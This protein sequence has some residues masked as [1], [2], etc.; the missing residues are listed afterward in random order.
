LKRITAHKRW[1]PEFANRRARV[2]LRPSVEDA[3][4]D[5]I[6]DRKATRKKQ[7]E[8]AGDYLAG[9]EGSNL[10]RL[11]LDAL[12]GH[13]ERELNPPKRE[14]PKR[15]ADLLGVVNPAEARKIT[16]LKKILCHLGAA[17]IAGVAFA[18]LLQ[19]LFELEGDESSPA[20]AIKLKMGEALR[21]KLAE[22]RLLKKRPKTY[23]WLKKTD[24]RRRN[25]AV[26]DQALDKWSAKAGFGAREWPHP[27]TSR[28]GDWLLKRCVDGLPHV[29][30]LDDDGVP[31][32]REEAIDLAKQLGVATAEY[33]PVLHPMSGYNRPKR[34]WP[35]IDYDAPNA[36]DLDAK[37]SQWLYEESE[38]Q[39]AKP[40]APWT[41]W[42]RGA[43]WHDGKN[44]WAFVNDDRA[45]GDIK[46][47]FAD[48][49]IRP[50]ADGVS[51]AQA[52]R[53]KINP[54]I[55]DAIDCYG[56]EMLRRK[57][58][59]KP[60]E[61]DSKLR[62]RINQAYVRA[63]IDLA[64]AYR[65]W[66]FVTPI[67]CDF[68]GRLYPIP[69]FNRTREDHVRSAFL[70]EKSKPLGERGLYWLKVHVANTFDLK[71]ENGQR[72][73]K[74]SFDERAAW[75][76]RNLD[77]IRT[78][79]TT[80]WWHKAA[81]PFQALA[82]AVELDAALKLDDPTKFKTHLPINLDCTCSGLQILTAMIRSPEGEK[83]NLTPSPRPRD[84]Y[85][86]VADCLRGLA[87]KDRAREILRG[88]EIDRD[89]VKRPTMTT[90]YGAR[91][92]MKQ[93]RKELAARGWGDNSCEEAARLLAKHFRTAIKQQARD[94]YGVMEFLR[95]LAEKLADID[96][97]LTWK[98][99]SGFPL[100]QSLLRP[101]VWICGLFHRARP[102]A[103]QGCRGR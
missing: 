37:T 78:A 32:V 8:E 24:R 53:W 19:A 87:E 101:R 16:R 58:K 56:M 28:A 52:V 57:I 33:R 62:K 68:R 22:Y 79:P 67:R 47:A 4:A 54:Q 29:F 103:A 39:P 76:D 99:P 85:Q 73:S 45:E 97:L 77:Q 20:L 90:F 84:I 95:E 94:A 17:E 40:P 9:A 13:I 23:A 7:L 6:R 91:K 80:L 59:R 89:L 75:T 27:L 66:T 74:L 44:S 70:F 51:A 41:G 98:S 38:I 36:R 21:H 15:L 60:Y 96:K 25:R 93:F 1:G 42:R 34:A 72:I 81:E 64:S 82:A 46:A 26:R 30:G 10:C 48:R 61:S 65:L 83:V 12:T 2:A 18:S 71:D 49:S 35:I 69:D 14:G 11:N 50:H 3:A 86:D 92:L 31:Y 102:A 55:V 100:V 63:V 88:L 5:R 43:Y